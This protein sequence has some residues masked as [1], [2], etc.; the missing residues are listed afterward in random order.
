MPFSTWTYIV[1]FAPA[2]AFV[3]LLALLVRRGTWRA[4]PSLVAIALNQLAA[5]VLLPATHQHRV[6]YFWVFYA[7]SALACLLRLWLLADVLRTFRPARLLGVSVPTLFA[8]FGAALTLAALWIGWHSGSALSLSNGPLPLVAAA[9]LDRAVNT[10]WV[11]FLIAAVIRLTAFDHGWTR[12][13]VYAASGLVISSGGAMLCRYLFTLAPAFA[14]DIADEAQSLVVL[15]GAILWCQAA[16]T[17]LEAPE[18]AHEPFGPLDVA[19]TPRG[20]TWRS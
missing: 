15:L 9:L 11:A 2:P 10:A 1:G 12:S 16:A 20:D 7:W 13:T 17:P 19:P 18:G 6:V 14:R 4:W 5:D 8:A 3:A